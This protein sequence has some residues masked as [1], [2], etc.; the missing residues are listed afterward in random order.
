MGHP[1][2]AF[3]WSHRILPPSPWQLYII[4]ADYRT[5]PPH[6]RYEVCAQSKEAAMN[7]FR[8][9]YSWLKIMNVY[10]APSNWIPNSWMNQPKRKGVVHG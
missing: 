1:T 2:T 5:L 8:S 9:T 6:P 10:R 4:E 7:W 3:L